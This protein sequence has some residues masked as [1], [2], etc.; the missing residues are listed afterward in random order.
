MPLSD[1]EA[2]LNGIPLSDIGT[3]SIT[4]DYSKRVDQT[5]VLAKRRETLPRTLTT[6]REPCLLRPASRA[7]TTL[8]WFLRPSTSY[9]LKTLLH[10]NASYRPG[11]GLI[12]SR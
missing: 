7:S 1:I 4:I 12:C 2:S 3:A 8:Q 11:L 9:E 10:L 6:T 5:K